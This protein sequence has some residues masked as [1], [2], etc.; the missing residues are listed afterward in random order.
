MKNLFL[1]F[2]IL[3]FSSPANAIHFFNGTY[4]EALRKAKDENK[5]IFISF[6]ASWCGPCRLMKKIVFENEKVTQYTDKHYISLL[7]DIEFKPYMLLQQQ[8]NPQRAGSIPH[9]CI[10]TPEEELLKENATVNVHQMMNFLKIT[11]NTKPIRKLLAAE[12]LPP[13]KENPRLFS[14]RTQYENIL[15]SAREENKNMLLCFSSHF[16]GPCRQMENTTFQNPAII[17]ATNRQYITG[18]FETGDP[19]DRALCHR[20]KN[21]Q[22]IIPYLVIAT[23]DEKIIR[24]KTGYMDSTTFMDFIHLPDH[25]SIIDTVSPS[26]PIN[27]SEKNPDWI[28]RFFYNQFLC[29]WKLSVI[30]GANTTTLRTSGSLSDIHFNYRAG[31]ELGVSLNHT[32]RRWHFAPGVSFIS[33]GGKNKDITLRQNYLEIPVKIGWLY[34][35]PGY[36]WSRSL[37]V[38]PYGSVRIGEKL[39][40]NNHLLPD[41]MFD[42]QRLDYGLRFSANFKFSSLCIEPGYNLGLHNISDYAGGQ[43]FNRGFFLNLWL[44]FGS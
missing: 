3:F 30:A 10:I 1:L 37:N 4:Q 2:L 29:K 34:W 7:L 38:T 13:V 24:K 19:K 44:N 23:P 5:N 16:C 32:T 43:M 27:Y 25:I 28:D 11:N 42:T 36:G 8:V 12:E 18:Y 20:Y 22:T 35:N 21:T 40:N 6:T 14:N 33:K 26:Y 9:I 41:E 39:K 15:A 17:E 31:Y